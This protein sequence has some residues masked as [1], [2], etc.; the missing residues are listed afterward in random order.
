M[1]R[2]VEVDSIIVISPKSYPELDG[3]HIVRVSYL[4]FRELLSF[5]KRGIERQR[6]NLFMQRGRIVQL[7]LNADIPREELF[8]TFIRRNFTPL[9]ERILIVLSHFNGSNVTIHQIYTYAKRRF[10]ISKDSIYKKI[11]EF[12]DREL[13]FFIDDI[14]NRNGKRLIL[15][16]LH[17][18]GYLSLSQKFMKHS[19]TLW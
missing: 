13:I 17:L 16:D 9:E 10:K 19:L 6:F 7:A 4:N 1:N 12:R 11:S 18:A 3:Y 5:H 2:D 14:L 8:K 15:F